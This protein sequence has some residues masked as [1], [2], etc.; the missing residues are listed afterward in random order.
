[1][2]KKHLGVP[3]I[4]C[5]WTGVPLETAVYFCPVLVKDKI[6]KQGHF[7]NWSCALA[8]AHHRSTVQ[9]GTLGCTQMSLA[10]FGNVQRRINVLAGHQVS[11]APSFLGLRHF[12]TNNGVQEGLTVDM[13][14]TKCNERKDEVF[15]VLVTPADTEIKDCIK[16]ELVPKDGSYEPMLN[17]TL[18]CSRL[19]RLIIEK[20]KIGKNK[21]IAMYCN[22]DAVAQGVNTIASKIAKITVH[23]PVLFVLTNKGF[24]GNPDQL[25]SFFKDTFIATFDKSCKAKTK[26]V[27]QVMDA[28][29]SMA[30]AAVE[31][32]ESPKKKQKKAVAAQAVTRKKKKS[33]RPSQAAA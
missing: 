20:P 31:V 16:Q 25:E 19:S 13:F 22:P 29:E 23:G 28:A 7:L 9:L 4:L 32:E 27:K 12:S 3:L 5:D 21:N 1:M 2:R 26:R 30:V 24:N 14:V 17:A 18:E 33:D 15:G 6:K 10:E 8:W 11:M